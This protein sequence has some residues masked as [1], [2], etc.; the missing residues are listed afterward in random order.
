MLPETEKAILKAETAFSKLDNSI[1]TAL[2][3]YSN[4]HRGSGHYSIVTTHL[5]DKAREIILE[6]LGLDK[7]D[8]TVVFCTPMRADAFQKHLK[9]GHYIILN[10]QDIGLS[11][12]V[13][14]IA[15]QKKALPKGV[16]FQTGGGTAKLSSKDW[17]IW[18]SAPGKFEAGT[19]QIIN[20]IAFS[21]ALCIIK[22]SGKESFNTDEYESSSVNDILYNDE[23]SQYIGQELLDRLKLELIGYRKEVP[24]AYGTKPF[25]NLDN[26]AS[27]Q[28]FKPV[29]R[30]YCMT[31]RA[32]SNLKEEVI[33]EVKNICSGFLNAPAKEYDILFTSNST[34]SINI[35]AQSF[36][37]KEWGDEEPVV[38]GTI[39]EHT[40]NDLP[41]RMISDGSIER[42]NADENGFIDLKAL[43]TKLIQYNLQRESGRKRI[44]LIAVTGAS[45]VLGTCNEIK[46][47]TRIAHKYDASVMVDAAQLVAHRQIDVKDLDIDYITFS[48]HK[49]YAPFGTGVLIAKKGIL[50]FSEEE[51][52]LI[53]Q[54]G[55]DN[56]AGI[57]SL[58]KMLLLMKRIG[59]DLIL[60]EE[61]LLTMK[62]LMAL[63]GLQGVQVYGIKDPDSPEFNHKAGVIVFGHDKLYANKLAK[64]LALAG[65]VGIR[66]GCHCAHIMVKKLLNLNPPLERIQWTIQKLLPKMQLPGVARI[67]IGLVNNESDID[68]FIKT[69]K[70]ITGKPDISEDNLESAVYSTEVV[71]E[72][73]T[74]FIKSVEKKVYY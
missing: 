17:V 27:T 68:G 65:G 7:K 71:K 1:Y 49:V 2:E 42:L 58:G 24:T 30:S 53:K 70:E 56:A 72:Q 26:A 8:Y 45:N 14:A 6:Y 52:S 48:A 20:V 54:S 57:A 22:E 23:L 73:I 62:A 21:K 3:T 74:A 18:S 50:N 69:L 11:L 47:I 16:P 19:P 38:R 15:V 66:F 12:G 55:E 60:K 32:P 33:E 44:K 39:M 35:A 61:K 41:W 37:K 46:A 9:E 29:F 40:S 64:Q 43:E 13:C 67:S 31:L 10:S 25:I 5:Y 28:T 4:V 34:E 51:F 59:M 36:I 63:K